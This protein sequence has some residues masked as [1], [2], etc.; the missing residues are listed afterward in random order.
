MWFTEYK[1]DDGYI[2]QIVS[3]NEET[4]PIFR[5]RAVLGSDGLYGLIIRDYNSG[6]MMD[7]S[8][9]TSKSWWEV[10]QEGQRRCQVILKE[11]YSEE[12]NGYY[13]TDPVPLAVQ[14]IKVG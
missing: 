7:D 11:I 9:F 10:L 5:L 14:L 13:I 12:M 4:T 3:L 2:E 1:M 6:C 8:F